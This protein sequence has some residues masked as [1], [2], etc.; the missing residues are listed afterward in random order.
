Y[1][2][3]NDVEN[4]PLNGNASWTAAGSSGTSSGAVSYDGSGKRVFWS[5]TGVSAGGAVRTVCEIYFYG[6]GGQKLATYGCNYNDFSGGD[7][8][9]NWSEKNRNV[10]F[11]GKPVQLNG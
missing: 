10:Y 4:R 2:N 11:A 1:T 8:Q 9:F 5:A 7:G 3:D 6:I